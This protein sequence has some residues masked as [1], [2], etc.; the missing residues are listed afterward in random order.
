MK[1]LIAI[2][3]ATVCVAIESFAGQFP[4]YLV[5]GPAYTNKTVIANS[6][7]NQIGVIAP[8]TTNSYNLVIG[9]SGYS[10][11]SYL[12]GGTQTAT[13]LWPSVA[14]NSSPGY[15]LTLYG[16]VNN[17]T[18]QCQFSCPP[19]G[20]TNAAGGLVL[21]FARSVDGINW[22]TNSDT[23]GLPLSANATNSLPAQTNI[24]LNGDIFLGL[25]ALYNTNAITITNILLEAGSKPGI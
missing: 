13:N 7:T 11:A 9:S 5:N 22:V 1:K 21:V 12:A 3:I 2:G 15:P 16:P 14:F 25:Q 19:G 17:V 18:L 6:L 20:T 8:L 23:W 4:T 10:S 24:T